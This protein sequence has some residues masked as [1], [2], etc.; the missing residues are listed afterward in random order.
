[1]VPAEYHPRPSD[2]VVGLGSL[3]R[4]TV[5]ND[6]VVKPPSWNSLMPVDDSIRETRDPDQ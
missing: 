1:V 5:E 3:A 4:R 6:P 2:R